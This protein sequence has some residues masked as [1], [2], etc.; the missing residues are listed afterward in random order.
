LSGGTRA[1]GDEVRHSHHLAMHCVAG[2]QFGVLCRK[3]GGKIRPQISHVVCEDSQPDNIDSQD[4][5]SGAALPQYL[6][7][8]FQ[9][10]LRR[11]RGRQG[12]GRWMAIPVS[13][14]NSR[15]SRSALHISSGCNHSRSRKVTVTGAGLRHAT[16]LWRVGSD[17]HKAVTRSVLRIGSGKRPRVRPS[18]LAERI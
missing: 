10:C 13:L 6:A 14:L 4:I 1:T 18:A 11:E 2:D 16:E 9:L 12:F 8:Q 5:G 15:N 17:A 7:C 3:F